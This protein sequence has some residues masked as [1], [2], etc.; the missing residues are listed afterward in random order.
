MAEGMS[1]SFPSLLFHE[2]RTYG[3]PEVVPI[4]LPQ[5]GQIRLQVADGNSLVLLFKCL[6]F[7]IFCHTTCPFEKFLLLIV[8]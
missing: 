7:S 4:S 1:F 2:G 5:S 8:L 3:Q 6:D